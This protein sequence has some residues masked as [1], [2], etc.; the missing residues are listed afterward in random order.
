MNREK[1]LS[2]GRGYIGLSPSAWHDGGQG[3]TI[4][5]GIVETSFGRLLAAATENGFCR[6]AFNEGAEALHLRFPKADLQER[7]PAFMGQL[8]ELAAGVETA[9]DLSHFPLDVKGT[10]FQQ[11]CGQALRAIPAGET[12]N[13]AQLAATVGKPGAVRAA[14]SANGANPVAL[15]IPCHRVIRSDGTL[16]GY[17]YGVDLKRALLERERRAVP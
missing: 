1:E 10:P 11:A 15:L 4:R 14:G 7:D 13:Y 6:V 3:V 8:A 12:R 9:G 2:G 16:G 17:A 5:W